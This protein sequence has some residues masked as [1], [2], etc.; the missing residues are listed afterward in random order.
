MLHTRQA[1]QLL[2]VLTTPACT[3]YA[4]VNIYIHKFKIKF[5]TFHWCKW[6]EHTPLL[7][8]FCWCLC[9]EHACCCRY[10]DSGWRSWMT[11]ICIWVAAHMALWTRFP[12]SVLVYLSVLNAAVGANC[13][14]LSTRWR[15]RWI[16]G[17]LVKLGYTWCIE[18][19]NSWHIA[20]HSALLSGE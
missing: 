18:L 10:S 12:I 7:Q 14:M 5:S 11:R 16:L 3:M 1:E 4:S 6:S 13:S 9:W 8:S 15:I 19:T 2:E 17:F 20:S